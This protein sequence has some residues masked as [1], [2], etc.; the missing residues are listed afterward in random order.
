MKRIMRV[1]GGCC[2][3]IYREIVATKTKKEAREL[4]GVSYSYFEDYYCETGNKKE[5]KIAMSKPRTVFRAK[6]NVSKEF[7]EK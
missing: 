6:D 7:F 4:F 5:I 3:G 2:S 1:W